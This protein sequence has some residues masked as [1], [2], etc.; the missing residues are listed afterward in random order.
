MFLKH[1]VQVDYGEGFVTTFA[2][3][4]KHRA[5]VYVDHTQRPFWLFPYMPLLPWLQAQLFDYLPL[6]SAGR[7]VTCGSVLLTCLVLFVY[8]SKRASRQAAVVGVGIFMACPVLMT[9]SCFVRPD[10]LALLLACCA[11]VCGDGSKSWRRDLLTGLLVALAL[12]TKQSYVSCLLALALDRFRRKDGFLRICCCCGLW[13]LIFFGV[14][15]GLTNG[16]LIRT[17]SERTMQKYSS[18]QAMD[19]LL[20]YLPF[21]IGPLALSIPRF[22]KTPIVWQNFFVFSLGMVVGSGRFGAI[23]NYYLEAHLALSVLSAFA[24]NS[25]TQKPTGIHLAIL[26]HLTL[27]VGFITIGYFYSVQDIYRQMWLPWRAGEAPPRFAPA[28]GRYL[29][30]APLMGADPQS[31]ISDDAGSF[32]NLGRPLCYSEPSTYLGLLQMGKWSEE[33]ILRLIEQNQ[34]DMI[35]LE[36]L[37]GN[38]RFS[39]EFIDTTRRCYHQLVSLP[40]LNVFV[41]KSRLPDYA[42]AIDKA[43]REQDVLRSQG[44]P[45]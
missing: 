25:W 6:F 41:P 3:A 9:F 16:E 20:D 11:L 31:I 37:D 39:Q 42:K 44:E 36:K 19:L 34:V 15:W 1:P 30:L 40:D 23:H 10:S 32:V 29:A 8:L 14:G 5:P 21:L 33:P 26:A 7:V 24:Y 22:F 45:K 28:L 27:P 43:S 18:Q 13:L 4:M 35:A 2:M 38:L 12:F 17:I